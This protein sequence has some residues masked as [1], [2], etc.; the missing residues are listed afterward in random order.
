M[1]SYGQ[2]S[3]KIRRR[4]NTDEIS[5]FLKKIDEKRERKIKDTGIKISYTYKCFLEQI[6]PV[7]KRVVQKYC[8]MILQFELH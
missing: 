1:Q 8:L 6:K 4:Y 2:D 7:M 5:K 3:N